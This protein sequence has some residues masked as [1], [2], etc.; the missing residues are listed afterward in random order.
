MF[1]TKSSFLNHTGADPVSFFPA[2]GVF[3]LSAQ[4]DTIHLF[5]F[6]KTINNQ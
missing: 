3:L 4:L 6:I 1:I 5:S 2:L